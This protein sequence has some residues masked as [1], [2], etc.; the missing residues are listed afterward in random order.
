MPDPSKGQQDAA[1]H[2]S[3]ETKAGLSAHDRAEFEETVWLLDTYK[4]SRHP[5]ARSP[6]ERLQRLLIFFCAIMFVGYLGRLACLGS[7]WAA[8]HLLGQAH[9]QGVITE[10]THFYGRSPP[11][12]PS[13]ELPCR[14][15]TVKDRS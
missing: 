8:S 12:Y 11:V 6:A 13:R 15:Q 3:Q 4:T 5:R 7:L 2:G 14:R 1:N 10:D 9:G